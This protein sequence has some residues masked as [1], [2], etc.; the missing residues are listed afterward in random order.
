MLSFCNIIRLLQFTISVDDETHVC[1]L[2][3]LTERSVNIRAFSL[4]RSKGENTIR[5]V[6]N[7]SG[8]EQGLVA[9][10]TVREVLETLKVFFTEQV[11]LLVPTRAVPGQLSTIYS[12]LLKRVDVRNS[13][14]D[15]RSNLV[16]ETNN[17]DLATRILENGANEVPIEPNCG[18][19]YCQE[20]CCQCCQQCF[21]EDYSDES[22]FS[23]PTCHGSKGHG[24]DRRKNHSC[25]KI[26]GHC[27]CST[28]DFHKDN[29][30]RVGK[31]GK[32]GALDQ[33][34]SHGCGGIKGR[35]HKACTNMC[36][37]RNPIGCLRD[38]ND[39][40]Q[41]HKH[42]LGYDKYVKGKRDGY[43]GGKSYNQ[44]E[45]ARKDLYK[46]PHGHHDETSCSS[47]PDGCEL[48]YEEKD[49]F[50]II[51]DDKCHGG[52]KKIPKSRAKKP[53]IYRP[54]KKVQK[55]EKKIEDCGC[56]K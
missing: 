15:E 5:F 40:K 49:C 13:Y 9:V 31:V 44:W 4:S 34:I 42:C 54:H 26:S 17:V 28:G 41:R 25:S 7:I 2:R 43:I 53:I 30:G 48:V 10:L 39:F 51:I 22:C 45:G 18:P 14:L 55:V 27:G 52:P 11:V 37:N 47:V 33:L 32:C 12:L 46:D 24:V 38:R 20:D 19:D 23:E 16:L 1:L 50:E 21:C 29:K 3:M 56:G 36:G 8:Q 6:P 35:P